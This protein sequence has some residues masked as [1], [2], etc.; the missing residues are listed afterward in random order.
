M[1]SGMEPV[2]ER[3]CAAN[4]HVSGGHPPAA[5][6]TG[7]A[8]AGSAELRTCELVVVQLEVRELGEVANAGWNRS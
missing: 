4:K 5:L 6:P 3:T 8:W 1:L 7:S 2:A